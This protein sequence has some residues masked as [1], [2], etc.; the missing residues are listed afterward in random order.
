MAQAGTVQ[1]TATYRERIAVPPGAV[2]EVAL[3]DVSLADAPAV[4]LSSQRYA[5]K[6]VPA[7]F[8]LSYDDALIA[9][10]MSYVVRASI[11]E[12]GKLLFTTD[13]AYPVL[14]RG[15]GD[16]V[17][18]VLVRVAEERAAVLDNTTWQATELNG[19]A[20][21][22]EKKPELAF[23]E[24]GA[25]SGNA[26]CNRFSGQAE[27]AEGEISFPGNMAVTMMACPPPYDEIERDFLQT[28]PTVQEYFVEGDQ[29]VL[30]NGAG[31]LVMRFEAK[32]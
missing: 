6:G 15:A 13:T 9:K 28:L 16:T 1:G 19:Q 25:I 11:R 10:N 5:L 23:A 2:L 20:L 7:E 24:A 27:I 21:E 32:K 22:V 12:A 18:L 30:A 31:D 17:D 8:Q 29:L 3:M 14:T 4:V 26:G